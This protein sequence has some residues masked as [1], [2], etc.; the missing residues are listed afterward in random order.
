MF[1][2]LRLYAS[3]Q[4]PAASSKEGTPQQRLDALEPIRD[5]VL[6]RALAVAFQLWPDE[7]HRQRVARYRL[8]P[9]IPYR[10]PLPSLGACGQIRA[11]TRPPRP[12]TRC[13]RSGCT[14]S[15]TSPPMR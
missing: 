1:E 14:C 8:Q 7:A 5:A 11:C 13:G 2:Y 10:N 15:K 9:A 6:Q 4:V 12:P 3:G